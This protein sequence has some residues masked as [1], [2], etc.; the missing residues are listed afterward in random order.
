MSIFAEPTAFALFLVL[1]ALWLLARHARQE[2]A[3]ARA[4]FGDP[5]LLA[6]TSTLQ[7]RWPAPAATSSWRWT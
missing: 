3:A 2:R 7:S 5:A 1:P 6:R 4:R